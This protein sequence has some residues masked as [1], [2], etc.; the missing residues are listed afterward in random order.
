[1][2][3]TK[4]APSTGSTAVQEDAMAAS[5]PVEEERGTYTRSPR[6]PHN[7]YWAGDFHRYPVDRRVPAP[8]YATR[9]LS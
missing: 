5:I 6:H 8:Q 7:G 2:T 1:M 9:P 3:S 4:P